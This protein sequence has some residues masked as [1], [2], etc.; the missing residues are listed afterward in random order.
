MDLSYN[1][2]YFEPND[3]TYKDIIDNYY[4]KSISIT[5]D[6]GFI[7]N[8]IASNIET[9][10][11]ILCNLNPK[12]E[13]IEI[14]FSGENPQTYCLLKTKSAIENNFIALKKLIELIGFPSKENHVKLKGKTRYLLYPNSNIDNLCNFIDAFKIEQPSINNS[15]LSDYIKTQSRNN[16]ISE[17]SVCIIS[18]TN[19]EVFI[20]YIGRT[21]ANERTPN[22]KVATYNLEHN[23]EVITMGCSVRNQQIGRGD[24]FYLISK[25][26]I[27]Q[28]G[29][30][31][32]DL[33]VQSET[34]NGIKEQRSKERKGLL[35]IYALD[36]RGTPN[37]KNDIPIIGYSLHFPRIENEVKVSYT[38]TLNKEFD[39][40]VMDD[41]DNP[42]SENQ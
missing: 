25:N 14:S 30:R 32:V 29:D 39:N 27:D 2:Q 23:G 33:S 42:E 40:E 7:H 8:P 26:Q 13:D 4:N 19:D 28:T 22:E 36:E 38:A 11:F 21:P 31:Q 16:T 20:D 24:E 9:I 18:N 6:F 17:W 3:D 15:T 1:Y 10:S 34:Y 12:F 5:Y 37:V 41:D 35:L